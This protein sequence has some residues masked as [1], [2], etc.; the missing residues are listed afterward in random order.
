MSK[1]YLDIRNWLAREEGQDLAEYAMLI[2]LIAVVVIVGVTALGG[3]LLTW[4]SG[5]AATVAT[6][7]T[8]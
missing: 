2:A 3:N 1:L 6:W 4:F 8:S 5:I 7:A